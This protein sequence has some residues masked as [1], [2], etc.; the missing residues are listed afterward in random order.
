MDPQKRAK[1]ETRNMTR[2]G[3]VAMTATHDALSGG[4]ALASEA[5]RRQER[6][7]CPCRRA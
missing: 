5:I 2:F 4:D 7:D 6:V 1:N 3:L